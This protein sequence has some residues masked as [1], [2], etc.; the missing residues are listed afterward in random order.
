M[1]TP[2]HNSQVGLP[3]WLSGLVGKELAHRQSGVFGARM[4]QVRKDFGGEERH[5]HSNCIYLILNRVIA[6][7]YK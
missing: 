1:V 4:A 2:S 7:S 3:S 6:R 5:R